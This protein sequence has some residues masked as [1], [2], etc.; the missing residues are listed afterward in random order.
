MLISSSPGLQ[1]EERVRRLK[2]LL[3]FVVATGYY[4]NLA[5]GEGD[6]IAVRLLQ[7]VEKCLVAKV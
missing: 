1:I 5:V 6:N 7:N 3:Q 2:G 4:E